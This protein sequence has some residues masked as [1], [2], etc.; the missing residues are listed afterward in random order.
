MAWR[1]KALSP[2]EPFVAVI[3][4]EALQIIVMGVSRTTWRPIDGNCERMRN[5]VGVFPFFSLFL[6]GVEDIET[7]LYGEPIAVSASLF[8]FI[9]KA[10]ILCLALITAF[11]YAFKLAAST[12]V[13]ETMLVEYCNTLRLPKKEKEKKDE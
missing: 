6:N 8:F 4:L 11:H 10:P 12:P 5:A 13:D 7:G 2:R 9:V 3:P 1:G